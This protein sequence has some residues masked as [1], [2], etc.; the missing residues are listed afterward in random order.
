M[1]TIYTEDGITRVLDRIMELERKYGSDK[2]IVLA[3][4]HE[5]MACNGRWLIGEN[6]FFGLGVD[7]GD[8]YI[9][10]M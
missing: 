8:R 2:I 9:L 6:R 7:N 5:D 10:G 3:G 1:A 4:N